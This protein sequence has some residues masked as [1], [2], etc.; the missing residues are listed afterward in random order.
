MP[1]FT[2]ED[3]ERS[4]IMV[5]NAVGKCFVCQKETVFADIDYQCWICS[6]ECQDKMNPATKQEVQAG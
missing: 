6:T 3:P 4:I 1:E 2:G 5:D